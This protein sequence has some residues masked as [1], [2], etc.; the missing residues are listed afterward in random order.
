MTLSVQGQSLRTSPEGRGTLI[1]RCSEVAR[2]DYYSVYLPG[3][4]VTAEMTG[5]SRA[6]IFRFVYD[7]DGEG[8]LVVN[9]NSDEGEGYIEVDT[10]RREI[11][12]YNPV[13][14]IYQGWGEPA[15]FAG[16][17]TVRLAPGTKITGFGTFVGDTPLPDSVCI[18]NRHGIGG[19]IKFE[20]KAGKPVTVKA[21][22][23][24]TSAEGADR[25][26]AAEIPGWDFD[27]VRKESVRRWEERLGRIIVKGGE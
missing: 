1:D 22:S 26:L 8:C 14:R 20:A 24:F 18:S 4:G 17:F 25:N 9:P 15:G 13:H 27:S 21:G 2:P 19:Y 16:H 23:S 5:L 3:E 6:G 12:G 10:L 7:G 11:R